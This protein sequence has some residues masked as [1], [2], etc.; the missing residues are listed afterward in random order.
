[1]W[2]SKREVPLF[3]LGLKF[4][5]PGHSVRLPSL[6]HYEAEIDFHEEHNCK[7]KEI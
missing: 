1:L 3:L 5:S 2:Y 6:G 7:Y 4:V